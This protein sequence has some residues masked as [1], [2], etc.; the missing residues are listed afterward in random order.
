VILDMD[1]GLK[2]TIESV[3]EAI[4]SET[5][6]SAVG[7]RLQDGYDFPFFS[8]K[9]FPTVFLK[10]ENSLIHTADLSAC[11]SIDKTKL[12]CTCGLVLS[13]GGRTL[14]DTHKTRYGSFWTNNSLPMLD[15]AP[16]DD[17]RYMPRNTCVKMG[18]SSI[19][20]IPIRSHGSAIGTIQLND[21]RQDA[22]TEKII[23]FFEDLSLL[24]GNAIVRKQVEKSLAATEKKITEIQEI[25]HIGS[26]TYD[27]K[28]D[29]WTSSQVMDKVFGIQHEYQ[30]NFKSWLGIIHP[31]HRDMMKTY[32]EQEVI[33]MHRNFHKEYKI[34]RISDE[35]ERWVLGFGELK[36]DKDG[37]PE[38]L[39][40]AIMDITER[41][42]AELQRDALIQH[43]TS[44][45]QD[46][47]QFSHIVSHN[48]RAPIANLIGLT[49]LM[50]GENKERT[51]FQ[52]IIDG[53]SS[54]AIILDNITKDLNHLL[55]V[56]ARQTG[57]REEVFFEE[58]VQ[59]IKLSIGLLLK[60]AGATIYTDF[61]SAGCMYT[62]RSYLHSIFSNLISNGIKYHRPGVPPVL[63]IRSCK[64]VD[65]L[66]I[67][68]SDNGTGIDLT[69]HGQALFRPFKRFDQ[70]SSGTGMGLY[71]VKMQVEALGGK[72]AVT[73]KVNEGT[74]FTMSFK[75]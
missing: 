60:D 3:V 4:H 49:D 50:N 68:F 16:E 21:L 11:S 28:N 41:K 54:S 20:I 39:F 67:V 40:G 25:A 62:S 45:N 38:T 18:Y 63:R 33:G 52:T 26:Y 46:L 22:F 29:V 34:I 8:E 27:I 1:T 75:L 5:N 65:M 6:Y 9:G 43:L 30:K 44:R 24:I 56:K 32:L 7:I 23:Y 31:D 47:E 72:I 37:R 57:Q 74:S 12:A 19:A 69:K 61:L 48:L 58:L 10:T 55:E 64:N 71:M 66:E 36:F 53:I 42:E 13:G 51:D 17:P 70:N 14:N 73:S 35:K 15:M 59:N 2:E